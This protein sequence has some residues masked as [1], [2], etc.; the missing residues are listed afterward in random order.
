MYNLA[1]ACNF[2]DSRDRIIRD[3]LIVGCNSTSA[4]DK[5]VQKGENITLNEVIE[6]LQIESSTHQT[7]QEMSSTTQKSQLCF[8][9][10]EEIQRKEESTDCSFQY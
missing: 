10:Q 4:R 5:I 8:I 9:W 6:F 3:L 2:K 7:L 1:D